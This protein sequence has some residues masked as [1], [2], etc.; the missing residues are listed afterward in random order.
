MLYELLEFI[1]LIILI[2]IATI[3]FIYLYNYLQIDNY[4][5]FKDTTEEV[6]PEESETLEE[7]KEEFQLKKYRSNIGLSALDEEFHEEDDSEET[8]SYPHLIEAIKN[9]QFLEKYMDALK[10]S[11][12]YKKAL[13]TKRLKEVEKDI[14]IY[15]PSNPSVGELHNTNL[16]KLKHYKNEIL[17]ILR[18]LEIRQNNLSLKVVEKNFRSM[19][20]NK[21]KGLC[22]LIGRD[23]IKDNMASLVYIFSKNP[24]VIYSKFI[25]YILYGN[26]G[27]GK[28]KLIETMAFF[29][30][31][32][33]ILL[34]EKYRCV[35][36]QDFKSPYINE[37]GKL[38][39]EILLNSLEG[40]LLID[41][42]Y[43]WIPE[44][45]GIFTVK[46][47][48]EESLTEAVN[49]WDKNMGLSITCL[50]GYKDKLQPVIE[51]NQGMDRRF[52]NKIILSDYT[53]KELTQI[54][55]KF[56]GLS[57]EDIIIGQ[58]EANRLYTI[59]DSIY[60]T[61]KEVFSRQAGSMLNL[62]GCILDTIYSSKAYS[63]I[64]GNCDDNITLLYKGI[65]NYLK[66][67]KLS[68]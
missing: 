47:H 48:G 45:K 62:S 18:V 30:C 50:A 7:S 9:K 32:S 8:F 21:H 66:T 29:F 15:V 55:I 68:I 14:K 10:I 46:D 51:S 60:K 33:G 38:A 56:I 22:S 27:A 63:W 40:V 43:Q 58:E 25:N 41:E 35:T 1:Y 57:D 20:Y 24:R 53:S 3:V 13:Y 52:P 54:L 2:L 36:T 26:S 5:N 61:S 16:D 44:D 12:E 28:T 17:D 4:I 31:K 39:R 37:S 67:F 49:F 34:R 42:A 19:I 11:Y 23:E 6:E 59:I 65:K 64:N